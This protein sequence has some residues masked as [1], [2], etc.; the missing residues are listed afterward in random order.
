MRGQKSPCEEPRDS[1]VYEMN[2]ADA[3]MRM[4]GQSDKCEKQFQRVL[5]PWSSSG[6][7]VRTKIHLL[8][9]CP[10]KEQR[11]TSTH[12]SDQQCTLVSVSAYH[13]L[14]RGTRPALVMTDPGPGAWTAHC[15]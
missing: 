4:G 14:L 5:W 15:G 3:L 11:V 8:L 7:S 1:C 12:G 13:S 9:L 10:P 6:L 2:R